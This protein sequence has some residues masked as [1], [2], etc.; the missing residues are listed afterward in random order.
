MKKYLQDLFTQWNI[1]KCPECGSSDF[2]WITTDS[3]EWIVMEAAIVCEKCET[4]VNYWAHGIYEEPLLF[5]FNRM[6]IKEVIIQG[7]FGFTELEREHCVQLIKYKEVD[8]SKIITHEFS[9][10]QAKE[11]FEVACNIEKS[12]KVI[13][14]PDL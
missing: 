9:L 6:V 3:M 1:I 10:D 7:S 8:R 5:H 2:E 11:A 13:V 4:Y 14:K 12:V